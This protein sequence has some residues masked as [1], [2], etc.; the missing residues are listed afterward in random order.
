MLLL[1]ISLATTAATAEAAPFSTMEMQ[2]ARPAPGRD[3]DIGGLNTKVV[4]GEEAGLLQAA[5]GLDQPARHGCHPP[6]PHV[7]A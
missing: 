7:R 2:A 5:V 1:S 4:E 6:H 3:A